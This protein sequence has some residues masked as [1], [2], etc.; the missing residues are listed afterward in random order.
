VL[1]D[2]NGLNVTVRDGRSPG[3]AAESLEELCVGSKGDVSLIVVAMISAIYDQDAYD[4]G[5]GENGDV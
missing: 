1:T 2:V 5:S 4:T 3:R